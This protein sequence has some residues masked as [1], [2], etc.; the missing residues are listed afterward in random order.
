[1]CDENVGRYLSALAAN[2][3][4]R[5]VIGN[6]AWIPEYVPNVLRTNHPLSYLNTIV[7]RAINHIV[8]NEV[9]AVPNYA[10]AIVFDS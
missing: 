4:K 6:F 1:M 7:G 8:N 2:R 10:G 3:N 9:P 5:S